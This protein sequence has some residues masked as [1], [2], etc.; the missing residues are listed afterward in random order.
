LHRHIRQS[1]RFDRFGGGFVE[2]LPA[3]QTMEG[4][5]WYQGTADAVRQQLSCIE[6]PGVDYVLVL[7]GDQLYRMDFQ[8]MLKTLKEASADAT[9]AALPVDDEAAKGFGI[10]RLDDTGRVRGFLEKPQT[11]V[12]LADMRT[13]PEWI[14]ERGISAHGRTLLASMGIYH[15]KRHTL[16][17][18]LRG[19][20]YADFGREVFPMSIRARNVNVHLFD[21][22][23]EDIGTIRAFFDA[24]LALA[25]ANPPFDMNDDTAPIYTR[26]R[27]LAPTRMRDVTV[28]SSLISNGG[29]IDSGTTIDNCVVGV[30]S[31]IGSNVSL[32]NCIVMGA[33]YYDDN[34]G[35]PIAGTEP[36]IGNGTTIENAI[37]DKNCRIG[38]NVTIKMREGIESECDMKGL[39][40]RDGIIV[41][42]KGSVI[43]DDFVL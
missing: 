28:K 12:E 11:T 23:W 37:L 18:M 36:A 19:S 29:F 5:N 20:D 35:V 41:V 17:Q 43:P 22:Y 14:E 40:I 24:N 26:S 15:F 6:Q 3:Q 7:S 4:A 10:M 42:P 30:R 32:R 9:I 38:K 31:N 27:F 34:T 8:K 1:Y 2:L 39:V 25:G 33:D 13:T 16:V 21:G